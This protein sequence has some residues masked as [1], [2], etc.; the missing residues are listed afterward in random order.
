MNQLLLPF[1]MSLN[2]TQK[3]DLWALKLLFVFSHHHVF[4]NGLF[5]LHVM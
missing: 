2:G 1:F 5:Q 3:I 4:L